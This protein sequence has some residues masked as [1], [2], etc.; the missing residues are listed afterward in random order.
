MKNIDLKITER[1]E[2]VRKFLNTMFDEILETLGSPYEEITIHLTIKPE[3]PHS[4]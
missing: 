2:L 3:D 4:R 1:F